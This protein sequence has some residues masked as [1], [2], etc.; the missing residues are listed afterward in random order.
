MVKLHKRL[1]AKPKKTS[2][3]DLE[4]WNNR[5]WELRLVHTSLQ[6]AVLA[7][8]LRPWAWRAVKLVR[9]K[10]KT[11]WLSWRNTDAVGLRKV[12][13]ETVRLSAGW[14]LNMEEKRG[15][16]RRVV[17]SKS[18]SLLQEQAEMQK[19][20]ERGQAQWRWMGKPNK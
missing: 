7:L 19:V 15:K 14:M 16:V 12:L 6:S 2:A 4:A 10:A 11:Q 17:L 5:T 8:V 1:E 13:P 9:V 20:W 3:E 18:Q